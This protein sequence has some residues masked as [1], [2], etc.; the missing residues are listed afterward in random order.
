M[1]TVNINDELHQKLKKHCRKSGLRINEY[2][3]EII[4]EKMIQPTKSKLPQILRNSENEV[5]EIIGCNFISSEIK[6]NLPR[7]ISLIRNTQDGSGFIAN[8]IQK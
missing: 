3:T 6:N 8:Y 4:E 2:V 1:K 7:E 5:I